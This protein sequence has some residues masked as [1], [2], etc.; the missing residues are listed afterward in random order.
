MVLQ[1]IHR[2]PDG[3]GGWLGRAGLVTVFVSLQMQ[4]GF[5]NIIRLELGWAGLGWAELGWGGW[6]GLPNMGSLFP[7]LVHVSARGPQFSL[8]AS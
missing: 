1:T 6:A 5:I 2:I 7:R 8:A 3:G 4:I